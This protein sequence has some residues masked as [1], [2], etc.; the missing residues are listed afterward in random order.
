LKFRARI[1]IGL[2]KDYKD[3]ESETVKRTLL[4]LNFDVID[5]R[6]HKV[7]EMTIEAGTKKDAETSVRAMCTRLLANPTKDEFKFEVEPI[8]SSST[9]EKN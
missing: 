5:V 6:T 1:E 9:T 8:G 7:Y 2:R 3:P 4:D